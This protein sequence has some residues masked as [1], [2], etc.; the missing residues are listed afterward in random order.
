MKLDP[1]FF[2]FHPFICLPVGLLHICELFFIC[3]RCF[4]SVFIVTGMVARTRRKDSLW[5]ESA[6]SSIIIVARNRNPIF[7]PARLNENSDEKGVLV[8][9]PAHYPFSQPKWK[10]VE[11]KKHLP[12]LGTPLIPFVQCL[13]L[14]AAPRHSYVFKF[15]AMQT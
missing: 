10:V 1:I 7:S 11:K 9:F 12:M 8:V 2:V 6:Q 4:H 15:P 5:F 13:E 3:L 14:P